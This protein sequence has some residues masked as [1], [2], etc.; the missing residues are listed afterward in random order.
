MTDPPPARLVEAVLAVDIGG[1]KTAAALVDR[2]GALLARDAAPTPGADGPAAILGTALTLAQRLAGAADVRVRAVG[3]G[4]AGVVDVGL[5]RIVSATDTLAAWAGTDVAGAL[6]TGLAGMIGEVPVHVQNDV[7]AFAVGEVWRGAARG[8]RSVLV[9]AVGTGIGGAVV[10]GGQVLRG[11]HHVAGEIGHVPISGAGHLLCTCGRTGHLEALASGVGLHRH[12][13]S[14]GG[15][16]AD[17]REVATRADA[18]EP[19]AAQAVADSGAAAGRGIA[20]VVT[21][22]DP[23]CV[24]VAGSVAVPGS[25][26]WRAMEASLR[27]QLIDVLHDVPV[28]PGVLGSDAPLAG[29]AASAWECV[30]KESR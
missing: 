19:R 3:V 29:A 17:G 26:W 30:Q 27:V 4:T 9:V 15:T 13:L 2:S 20:A 28:L 6:R 18:G 10:L 14:L 5:G 1:T 7:D 25:P 11:A 22:L 24:V 12:Y 8:R 21:V 16:A 23:E